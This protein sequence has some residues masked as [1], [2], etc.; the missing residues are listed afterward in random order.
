MLR[1]SRTAYKPAQESVRWLV[2][3]TASDEL[4]K[5]DAAESAPLREGALCPEDSSHTEGE[6]CGP[7]G[8]AS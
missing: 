2:R 6:L 5:R 4:E 3:T 7:R 8:D 1:K